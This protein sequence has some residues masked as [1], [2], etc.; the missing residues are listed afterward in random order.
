MSVI[1][2]ND[3]DA[4]A[5]CDQQ[6]K[7]IF[8]KLT[9][10]ELG[11][12]N[13]GPRG[14]DVPKEGWYVVRPIVN[15]LGLGVG[16][17]MCYITPETTLDLIPDGHFW[18]EFHQGTHFSIDYQNFQPVFACVGIKAGGRKSHSFKFSR[19]YTVN[20]DDVHRFPQ[21]IK[22]RLHGDYHTINIEFIDNKIVEVHLRANP[23][24]S[25][26]VGNELFYN[27]DVDIIDPIT[28]DQFYNI[29]VDYRLNE[30]YD[31]IQQ[32]IEPLINRYGFG[33]IYKPKVG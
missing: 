11:E 7:W 13:C 28:F 27:K 24:F 8:N 3:V 22:Q 14:I 2:A 6:D 16:A 1:F 26:I 32:S 4:W 23:D 30:V 29:G 9:V 12:V 18:S 20:P 25:Y 19:W 17:R 15:L 21:L 5:K 33:I 31:D 10:Q